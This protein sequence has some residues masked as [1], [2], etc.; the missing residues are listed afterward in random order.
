MDTRFATVI[1]ILGFAV[2]CSE[3][4]SVAVDDDEQDTVTEA[5]TCKGIYPSY[6]QDPEFPEMY[7]GQT[8]SNQPPPGY[9][10]P[11]FR[12]SDDFPRARPDEAAD[13]PWRAP[14]FDALFAA[15]TDETTKRELADD[16]IWAVLTYIQEGNIDSGDVDTDWDVCNNEIRPWYNI[17]FQT[18]DVLAGRE[19]THGLTREAP[20]SFSMNTSDEAL[21]GTMWAIGFFNPTAAYTLGQTWQS[22]G[23]ASAPTD[24]VSFDEGAVVGKPLFTT[25]NAVG[26]PNLNNMPAWQ[27]NISDPKFCQCH[28]GDAAKCT[29]AEESQQCPRSLG[30]W[31]PVTLLQF[32]IAVKDSRAQGTEWV[33][34]TFV[35][36]G[37]RKADEPNPWNRISPLGL[38]WGNSTPPAGQLASTY[39]DNPRDNGFADMVIFWDTVDMLNEDGGADTFAHPGHLGCN[40][41]LDGPADK[42]YSSCMSCH[43]TASVVDS[44]LKVPPIAAQF[45]KLTNECTLPPDPD[46]PSNRIDASGRKAEE[47]RVGGDGPLITFEEID[48]IYF[49]STGAAVPFNTT[50]TR[51]SEVINVLPGEPDYQGSGR[52]NWI[53][54]DYSLQFSISLVQWAQWQEHALAENL[55][56]DGRVHSAKL[57]R[58]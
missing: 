9:S 17:P 57:P 51:G 31:G 20:V 1:L 22:D 41:R 30:D 25:I 42:A 34:G 7:A 21:G 35:A 12:L 48:S 45:G 6:W 55:S 58:R 8:V 23:T 19:F 29:M 28:P 50:I 40:S 14:R 47:K 54:L 24:N 52:T 26:M 3:R 37:Q 15:G 16:Y 44:N 10:G 18:Y 27:A 36:D 38:M 33:F 5:G 49:A 11:V 2:G 43:G 4:P 56:P 32:D 53:S 46:D 39:P 13:Q